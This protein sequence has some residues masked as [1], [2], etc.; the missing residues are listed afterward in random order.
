MCLSVALF[1]IFSRSL[2]LSL[3][4]H[5]S[6]SLSATP[7]LRENSH[8]RRSSFGSCRILSRVK[9]LIVE[10]LRAPQAVGVVELEQVRALAR[11]RVR[12]GVHFLVTLAPVDRYDDRDGIARTER[13]AGRTHLAAL[14]LA[15]LQIFRTN[16]LCTGDGIGNWCTLALGHWEPLLLRW[17]R[18][19]TITY[20]RP[21][22]SCRRPRRFR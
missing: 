10:R 18:F 1:P 11:V 3:P 17:V 6:V 19:S 12:T 15:A 5:L 20:H 4:H 14:H 16:D 21:P 7:F 8:I 9:H 22:L 13:T 2:H